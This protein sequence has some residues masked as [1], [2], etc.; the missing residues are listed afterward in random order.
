[1]ASPN[2]GEG[3]SSLPGF[4]RSLSSP[5]PAPVVPHKKGKDWIKATFKKRDC[6]FFVPANEHENELENALCLCGR[7]Q[8]A[9]K[10]LYAI[11]DHGDEWEPPS[12]TIKSTT[13]AYGELEFQGAWSVTRSKYIRVS[14]DVRASNLLR[15][16]TKEWGLEYPKLLIEVTGGAKN[17]VMQ[18]KL[19]R[20]F[21]H[22][23]IKAATTTNAW[24]LTGGTNTGVMKYVGEALHEHN[25]RS[26]RRIV[27]IGIAT[28]G[29]VHNRQD[30]TKRGQ[31]VSYRLH[32]SSDAKGA[33]LDPN[34]TH[35][36]LVDD[37][38]VGQYGADI[39]IRAKL[40]K[41]MAQTNDFAGEFNELFIDRAIPA[42]CVVLGGGLNTIKVVLKNIT[43]NPIIPAV[44]VNGSGQGA[45]LMAYAY[46]KS[47]ENGEITEEHI[48]QLER[49]IAE[50]FPQN[51][52]KHGHVLK[53][54][55]KIAK[56][57]SQITVYCADDEGDI[58]HAILNALHK[59]TNLSPPR[60]LR[61]A[62]NWNR[63]DVAKD[64]FQE[65]TQWEERDLYECFQISLSLNRVGFAA[66][67]MEQAVDVGAF[68]TMERLE[69]L[70]NSKVP[71]RK[72]F[73]MLLE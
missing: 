17:F 2:T 72:F 49:K 64:I 45:D 12:H 51:K 71:K 20:I 69:N 53:D 41:L 60:Q 35:L 43:R 70:Y 3:S 61:L 46:Q 59:A 52:D 16:L 47:D 57:K 37:G 66:L 33:S 28:W 25:I 62:L 19:R 9:H 8:K 42:V 6:C 4:V 22:G 38:T 63:V 58:D 10:I 5:G 29:I 23:I 56:N 30:M 34:H 54:L 13:D 73:G 7:T 11:G 50:V 68:L 39:P 32:G 18:P 65:T 21:R 48:A 14:S 15:L 24:V 27:A 36:I 26:Q 44:V 31:I 40:L 67:L 55:C 1:M